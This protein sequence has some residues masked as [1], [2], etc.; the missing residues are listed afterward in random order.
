MSTI[1]R[2]IIRYEDLVNNTFE[3]KL[4]LINFLSEIIGSSVDED[5]INFCIDQSDFKRLKRLENDKS[6]PESSNKF[7]NSGKIGQWKTKLSVEQIKKIETFCKVEM[8]ELGY[9]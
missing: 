9:L 3:T 1:P 6:F 2:I 4:K 8:K 5:H 7:F